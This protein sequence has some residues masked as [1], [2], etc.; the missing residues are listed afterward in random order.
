MP[1]PEAGRAERA[2]WLRLVLTPGIGPAKARQLLASFGLPEEVF[3][4]NPQ[5]LARVVGE[6]AAHALHAPTPQL[7]RQLEQSLEWAQA[8][9]HHL[10]C[11]TDPEYPPQFL[12]ITDPPPLLF[13]RGNPALLSRPAL[14]IVGSRSASR[15]GQDTARAFA[16]TLAQA[17]LTISSGLA[18][19]IDASAHA[20]ALG[21]TA[22]T[23]GILGNGVDAPYPASNRKLAEQIVSEGG[24]L[25]SEFALGSEP[26][27]SNFPRRNRLIAGLSLGVL[28]VEA[29]LRSG[30][31]ITAR[32][33]ADFGREVFAI[34]GSIHATLAKGCHHL[35]KQGAKL[36]ESAQDILSELPGHQAIAIAQRPAPSLAGRIDRCDET[37]IAM[38]GLNRL[39]DRRGLG[40]TPAV[41][42]DEPL[43]QVLGWDPLTAD[44]LGARLAQ[45]GKEPTNLAAQLL[46]L[47]MQGLVEQ[48]ADGR[49]QRRALT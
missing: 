36:V 4:A 43:L 46:T 20:G 1:V 9:D 47:E 28:V 3:E 30:S 29:A 32:Q 45:D 40:S 31:L 12:E 17:G 7:T 44:A 8:P 19:G 41:V 48:L 39:I 33:A 27:A 21:T 5:A 34:P 2:A 10:L 14:A 23:V 22:S 38:E 25:F 16:R 6:R 13:V 18:A 24:A 15:S 42:D 11:L 49:F 37:S 26:R 35:I